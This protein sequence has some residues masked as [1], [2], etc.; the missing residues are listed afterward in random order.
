MHTHEP[1]WHCVPLGQ[2]TQVTPPVPQAAFVLPVL[3]VLPSQH[4]EQLAV[5]H[6]HEPF[7]H[8][9]PLGQA[10]QVTP[11]VPQAWFVLPAL[12]VLFSQQPVGQLVAV[13]T[14]LPP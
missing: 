3:Q 10:T 8:C 7:W 5:V 2:A 13:H 12:Q 11:P 6:T 4:P 1:F 14:Q 9:V